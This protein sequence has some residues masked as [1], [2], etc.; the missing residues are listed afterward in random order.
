MLVN[1]DLQRAIRTASVAALMHW[2]G[3]K[4][5]TAWRWWT[6]LKVEGWTNTRGT[7]RLVKETAECGGAAI[8]AKDWTDDE[9]DA[10]SA[11]SKRLGLCPPNR[12]TPTGWTPEQ[13]ALLGTD[14]DEAI[15]ERL[16]RSR[17][18]VRAMRFRRGIPP[19]AGA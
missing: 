19:G 10:K 6:W 3:V 7:R 13:L 14:T 17:S 11:T 2:F 4:V 9:L 12:W 16:R 1:A 18:A 15:A 5:T 8:K